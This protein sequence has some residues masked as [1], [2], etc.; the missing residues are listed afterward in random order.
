MRISAKKIILNGKISVPQ[1]IHCLN[2]LVRNFLRIDINDTVKKSEASKDLMNF[3]T[4]NNCSVNLLINSLT[5]KNENVR[6]F[7]AHVLR[8]QQEICPEVVDA[9]LN[10]KNDSSD[11]VTAEASDTLYTLIKSHPS[12]VILRLIEILK[13]SKKED[14]QSQD[15]VATILF[16]IG[17]ENPGILKT[18]MKQSKQGKIDPR[19]QNVLNQLKERVNPSS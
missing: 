5:H 9:L 12:V 7:A 8:S 2:R 6:I 16:N 4:R 10:T 14:L 17:I 15:F 19:L 11:K 3:A 18:C 13:T 1:T